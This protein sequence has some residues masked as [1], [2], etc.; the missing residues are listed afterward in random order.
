V[1]FG[2]GTYITCDLGDVPAN[3]VV[4]KVTKCNGYPVAKI[5]NDNGKTMCRDEEYIAYLK[6]CIEWRLTHENA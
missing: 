5:S 6:R 1:S 3:N 4:M 2:I